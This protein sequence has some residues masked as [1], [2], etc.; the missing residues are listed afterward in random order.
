MSHY[1]KVEAQRITGDNYKD[2]IGISR[3]SPIYYQLKK[4]AKDLKEARDTIAR[5][6]VPA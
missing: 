5:F 1:R 3:D 6:D 2:I 4:V